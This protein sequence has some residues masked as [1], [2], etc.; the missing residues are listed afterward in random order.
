MLVFIV[1]VKSARIS[2]SWEHF[3]K[4][5]D[6]CMKSLCNQ[7]SSDFRVIVACHERPAT[8]FTHPNIVYV[9]V[10]FPI[11]TWE[12]ETDHSSRE[13]DK[14]RKLFMALLEARRFKPTHIMFVDSDDCVSK[15]LVEYVN[16]N[17]QQNGWFLEQGYEYRDGENL[18]LRRK[19]KF[20]KK[21]GT[22]HIIRHNLIDPA[23]YIKLEDI[24][25]GFFYHQ[26]LVEKMEDNGTPLKPFP[27]EGAV[28]VTENG[29]NYTN[30]KKLFVQ[31]FR[32][33]PIALLGLY[34]RRMYKSMSSRSLTNSIR[35]EFSLYPL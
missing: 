12:V 21:C 16:Q 24:D 22:S 34:M 3:S 6:R 32:S 29:E 31:R 11:P 35:D 13:R 9:E 5:F 23:N 4:L 14:D 19:E 2:S 28:Y 25:H 33:S 20:H 1:P 17:P 10:D 30:Q 26:D 8:D 27:F 7:T 15:Q 18:I